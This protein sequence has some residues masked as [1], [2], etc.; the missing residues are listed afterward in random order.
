MMTTG[1]E[2]PG[3]TAADLVFNIEEKPHQK[4]SREGNDLVYN[5]K[6]PLVDALCGATVHLT[7]LDGRPLTVC[8]PC[9]VLPHACRLMVPGRQCS[10]VPCKPQD[11]FICQELH[12]LL[13]G[14]ARRQGSQDGSGVKGID[15]QALC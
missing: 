2:R 11:H 4:F 5:A 9:N 1:D 6:L 8:S 13:A 3:T 7:T 10:C 15:V 12:R 14:A